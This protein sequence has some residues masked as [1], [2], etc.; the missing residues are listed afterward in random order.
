[1]TL[2]ANQN[3]VNIFLNIK[4]KLLEYKKKIK[5]INNGIYH[6]HKKRH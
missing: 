1:M 6:K 4:K 2:K 3:E 5:K